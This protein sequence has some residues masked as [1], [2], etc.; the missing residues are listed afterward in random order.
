M[1]TPQTRSNR[2]PLLRLLAINC[3]AGMFVAVLMVGG[4]L[5]TDTAQLWTLISTTQD[6]VTPIVLL[7]FGLMLTLGSVAMGTA[8]MAL[9]Y[10]DDKEPP[11]GTR[12]RLVPALAYVKTRN[13]RR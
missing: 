3:L 5:W 9:P 6:P 12:E 10:E 8:I 2:N 1:S 4:L 7:G 13:S 11:K